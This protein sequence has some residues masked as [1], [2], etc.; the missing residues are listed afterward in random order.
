[1]SVTR[2]KPVTKSSCSYVIFYAIGKFVPAALVYHQIKL[3]SAYYN[4][5]IYK[6]CQIKI[7]ILAE[8]F[9][10]FK[11]KFTIYLTYYQKTLKLSRKNSIGEKH[12]CL[13]RI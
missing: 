11:Q 9:H 6:I 13:D 1:M 8:N 4:T 7:G 12:D 10:L 2:T 5:T 3:Q